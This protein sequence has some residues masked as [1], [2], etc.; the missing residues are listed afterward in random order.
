MMSDRKLPCPCTAAKGACRF[1]RTQ[2]KAPTGEFIDHIKNFMEL[3]N[4]GKNDANRGLRRRRR[5][6][7][8]DSGDLDQFPLFRIDQGGVFVCDLHQRFQDGSKPP[9][10]A[11]RSPEP[12]S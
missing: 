4:P 11:V 2:V 1:S 12:E 3:T 8:M 10:A 9:V 6:C 7:E 5:Q